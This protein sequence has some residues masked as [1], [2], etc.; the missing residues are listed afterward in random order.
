MEKTLMEEE[1][2]EEI[3]HKMGQRAFLQGPGSGSSQEEIAGEG[4]R[5]WL[6]KGLWQVEEE[7]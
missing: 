3:R 6:G 1:K 4:G 7:L 2:T 5:C